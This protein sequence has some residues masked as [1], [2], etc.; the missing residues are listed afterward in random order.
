MIRCLKLVFILTLSVLFLGS[1]LVSDAKAAPQI[2]ISK[3][4]DLGKI[5]QEPPTKLELNLKNSGNEDL[6]ISAI[7]TSCH[8]ITA[9]IFSEEIESPEFSRHKNKKWQGTIKAKESAKLIIE[10]DPTEHNVIGPFTRDVFISTNDPDNQNITINITGNVEVEGISDELSKE[11]W[12][13]W[14]VIPLILSTGFLDGINPCAIGVLLLFIAFLYTIRRTR[15]NI[16]WM[17][18]IYIAAI[19]I[20]YI[21]SE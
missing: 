7:S 21:V 6:I 15:K 14:K 5:P 17:G 2:D 12:N 8:C 4:H 3:E 11:K 1:F 10:F 9:K 20:A 13:F 19:Y 16:I 18:V